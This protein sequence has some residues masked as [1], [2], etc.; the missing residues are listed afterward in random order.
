MDRTAIVEH[1]MDQCKSLIDRILDEPAET[2]LAATSLTLFEQVRNVARHILQAK[3]DLADKE[4]KRQPVRPC[5][6]AT[7]LRYVHTRTVSPTTIFGP[8]TL[9]VRTFECPKCGQLWRPDDEI[10]GVPERGDFTDDVRFFYR[11]LAADLPHRGANTQLGRL[12][13]LRLSSCGA[14]SLLDRSAQDLRR[15]RQHQEQQDL[16]VVSELLERDDASRLRLE[17]AMDGGKAHIEGE[18]QEPKVATV[19]VRRLPP[20]RRPPTRGAVIARRY[21]CVLGSAEAFM[22]RIQVLLCEA[23]WQD[24]EVA[25]IVG[26]GAHWIWNAA[27]RHFP[28]VRQTLDYYHLSEHFYAF[29]QQLF[30]ETSE[31]VQPWGEGKLSSLLR[32]RVGD[33]IGALKRLRPKGKAVQEALRQ[34]LVYVTN[35]RQRIHYKVPWTQGLAVGSG[36][37]EGAWKHVIQSRCKRAGMRWKNA[38][39]LHVL[40][41]R[42]AYLNSTLD[43]FWASHGLALKTV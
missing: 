25:E 10:L 7:H 34:L 4:L 26:D 15:W 3:V 28:G 1:V 18:W 2:S 9:A 31:R 27:T 38:G 21:G 6:P 23:V 17:I 24:I 12:T 32:D 41:I 13:G 36:A 19:V 29:A 22:Q 8:I 16:Q 30:G 40:E 33:V 35:N 39:F 5:C 14:Q 42:L 20:R 43:D 37:V 11:P